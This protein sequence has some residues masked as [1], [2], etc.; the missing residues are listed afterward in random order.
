MTEPADPTTA[1]A[2]RR[3]AALVGLA[4]VVKLAVLLQLRGHPLLQPLGEL[5]TAY[6]V[7]VASRIARERVFAPVGAPVV[8]PLYLYFLASVFAAGGSLLTAQLIQIVLGSAAVGFVF[9]TARHWF[10]ERA[11]VVAAGLAILT[12][13]LTFNEVLIL[14]SALD[15]FLVAGA[16]CALTRA[17]SGGV[18]AHAAAGVALGLLS[19]NR[20]NAVIVA[21]AVAVILLAGRLRRHAPAPRGNREAEPQA[22][23]VESGGQAARAIVPAVVM[24][25]A[26]AGVLGANAARHYAATGDVV[27]I[28]SHGGLNLYIGNHDRADGTYTPVPGISPSIAGQA[29]DAAQVVEA[30]IGRVPTAGEVSDYF[31]GRAIEWITANPWDAGRLTLRKVAILLN[32]TDVPLNYSYA[33]YAREPGSILRALASGPW[34]L[35]PLGL[36]GLLWPALR[37]RRAGYW[38]WASFVPVYGASVVVFFI[39]DRYRMPLLVPL[40]AAA[41]AAGVRLFDLLRQRK[42]AAL[43]APAG[44]LVVA[45]LVVFADLRLD[46]GVSGEQTRRAVWLVERGRTDEARRYVESMSPSHTHPGVL[47]NRV[48]RA[49]LDAGRHGDATEFFGLALAIDG[50]RP[51]IRL[52]L[53]EALLKSGRPGEAASHLG[54]VVDESYDVEYSGALLVRALVLAGR[55]DAAIARLARL[56]DAAA[57]RGADGALDFGA[58]ALEHGAAAE[59][60]RWLRLAAQRAPENAEAREQLGI[61]LYL[62]G[63]ALAAVPHLEASCRIEPARAS[64]HLNLAAVYA[65]LAR[66]ADARRHATEALRLDPS[67]ARAAALLGALRK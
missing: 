10:G 28:A 67:E 30:A 32:R 19:L 36:A 43:L 6:Y 61:A 7:D 29:R 15:P 3:M 21:V 48:G 58:L 53:G 18:A 63:D 17:T 55:P 45:T 47:R 41:G 59:A 52:A 65:E 20:P 8:S 5:D 56:P 42:A 22:G 46:P 33:Y 35:L 51:A 26:L 12:G 2:R 31:T 50:P 1:V 27:L 64:A 24:T 38:V 25:A 60:V 49:L 9:A 37:E 40:C 57:G 44:A 11:A 34:L 13:P 62:L 16:L 66:H 54:A 39:A 23:I 14:Q 4:F